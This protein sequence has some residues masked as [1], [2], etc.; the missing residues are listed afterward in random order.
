LDNKQIE[1]DV[2]EVRDSCANPSLFPSGTDQNNFAA[3]T[4]TAVDGPTRTRIAIVV[5]F[6]TAAAKLIDRMTP[7]DK[8]RSRG[9]VRTAPDSSMLSIVVDTAAP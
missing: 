5:K 1:L 7:T 8:L 2:T 9:T 3:C 6:D 4:V